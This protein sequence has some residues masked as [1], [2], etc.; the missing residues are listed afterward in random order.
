MHRA[1]R[2]SLLFFFHSVL[3]NVPI[4]P[5]CNYQGSMSYL[6]SSQLQFDFIQSGK[7]KPFSVHEHPHLIRA[8]TFERDVEH[9]FTQSLTF[10]YLSSTRQVCK[11]TLLSRDFNLSVFGVLTL[12]MCIQ[13]KKLQGV[14]V[15]KGSSKSVE[16]EIPEIGLRL[17]L[18]SFAWSVSHITPYNVASLSTLHITT[19][20]PLGM[21]QGNKGALLRELLVSLSYLPKHPSHIANL[22]QPPP[23]QSQKERGH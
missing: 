13:E 17:L 4:Y 7:I 6:N 1:K 10:C 11:E 16:E 15:S 12:E 22:G 19:E 8:Y 9:L 14:Q 3:C 23:K 2:L 5:M 18:F 20:R 21:T